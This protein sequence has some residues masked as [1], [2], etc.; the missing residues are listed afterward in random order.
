VRRDSGAVVLVA[1]G[2]L[3]LRLA[4]TDAML[5]YV[6]PVM[7]IPLLITSVILLALGVWE[8]WV[9]LR[10]GSPDDEHGG[11]HKQHDHHEHHGTE[12]V[13]GHSHRHGGPGVAWLLLAPVLVTLIIA[14]GALQADA[15][16]RALPASPTPIS[17]LGPLPRPVDGV[18]ELPLAEFA[19]RSV[20]PEGQLDDKTVRVVGFVVDRG[21]GPTVARFRLSCCAADARVSEAALI[22]VADVPS[23]NTWVVVE[24][25]WVPG[26]PGEYAPAIQVGD[27][28]VIPQPAN[29]YQ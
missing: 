14:P 5:D 9:S 4:V 1:L 12:D 10:E 7:R 2:V 6:K 3:G 27:L 18:Y 28:R 25:T 22:G 11:D 23:E 19:A 29:P 21:D 16:K 17:E 15:V 13:H 26:P 8:F 20:G 24:G